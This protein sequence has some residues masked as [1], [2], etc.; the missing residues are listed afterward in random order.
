MSISKWVERIHKNRHKAAPFEMVTLET[1]HRLISPIVNAAVDGKGFEEVAPLRWVRFDGTPIRQMFAFPAWKGGVM[2]PR[3]GLSFDFVP[4]VS[5]NPV[6][7][8]RT[9]KSAMFDLTVDARDSA[10][11]ISLIHGEQ[12]I[13]QSSAAVVEKAVA[14]ADEFWQRVNSIEDVVAAFEWLR[15]YLSKGGLGFYNYT[16]H[17]VALA[18]VLAKIG[19][20][21]GSRRELSRFLA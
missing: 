10:M 16:Q 20:E 19:D 18:F 8:H 14:C 9:N 5:G 17:S 12:A 1:A 15:R 11:E 4:H 6:R 21:D 13:V 2:A 7:W 3:W